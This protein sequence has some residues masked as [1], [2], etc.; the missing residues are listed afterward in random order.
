MPKS[1]NLT[2]S[3]IAQE[4]ISLRDLIRW[5]VSEFNRSAINFGQGNDNAWDEA[6]YLLLYT[7]DLPIDTLEPYIDARLL[8]A[9][10]IKCVDIIKQRINTH[11]PAAYL[12]GEAW[13]QGFRFK[14]DERAII[15]RS[16]IA[17]L[18]MESFDPWIDDVA[19]INNILDLCTGSGCLAILAAHMFDYA[20]V[21]AV[22]ISEQALSLAGENVVLHGLQD[23]VHLIQSDLFTGLATDKKYDLIICNPPYVNSDSMANLPAEFLH[24]PQNA[25]AGG[26]DGMDLVRKILR[27]APA[28]MTENAY[29]VL[30]IGHEKDF[31]EAAFPN[32]QAMWLSTQN[33]SDQ[34]VLIHKSQ[35]QND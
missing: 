2:A 11:K 3:D 30:E 20:D 15:P 17:E 28:Y 6:V 21:D 10:R 27:S 32:L 8:L 26:T 33:A 12:T 35:L 4:L 25:L 16:P 18:I 13:L 19:G 22:D 24:E 5:S 1:D 9:E 7:L 31:F 34:I 14:I 23:R 29:L